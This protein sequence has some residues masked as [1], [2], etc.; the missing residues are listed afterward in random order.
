MFESEHFRA[1]GWTCDLCD[2]CDDHA[3]R[4]R[5]QRPRSVDV[6]VSAMEEERKRVVFP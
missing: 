2:P 1:Q 6:I 3:D 5:D 4:E